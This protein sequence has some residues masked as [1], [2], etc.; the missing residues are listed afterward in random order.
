MCS[1]FKIDLEDVVSAI[2]QEKEI[3]GMGKEK[4]KLFLLTYTMT[5]FVQN[6]KQS[7]KKRNVQRN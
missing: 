2:K 7:K 5:I 4:V 1:V 3:K 6:S